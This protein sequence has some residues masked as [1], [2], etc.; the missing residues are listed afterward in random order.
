MK[1]E[2]EGEMGLVDTA[3]ASAAFLGIARN[4]ITRGPEA[5]YA[6]HLA[7]SKNDLMESWKTTAKD[8]YEHRNLTF[9]ATA[10]LST[11]LTKKRGRIVPNGEAALTLFLRHYC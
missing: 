6:I 2:L 5:L 10:D 1:K 8:K 11:F 7:L 3:M 4:K 9:Y